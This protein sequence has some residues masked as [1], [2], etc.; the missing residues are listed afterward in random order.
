LKPIAESHVVADAGAVPLTRPNSMNL[1]STRIVWV[2][3]VVVVPLIVKFPPTVKFPLTEVVEVPAEP[4]MLMLVVEP[5][6]PLVPMLI[7]L[8]V[9]LAVAPVAKL[10]V[11]APVDAVNMFTDCAA[12]AVFPTVS[13]VAAP[14]KFTVVAVV[15]SKSNDAPP[16][17][18]DVVI[19]GLVPNTSAPVPV[20]LVTADAKFADEGVARNVATLAANPETPV[21]IGRPA[22][23]LKVPDC[24]VPK[25]GVVRV[26]EVLSTL[27]PEPVLVVTPVP[28]FATANVP[29]RVTAPLVAVLGVRPVV[30]AENDDTPVPATELLNELYHCVVEE[31]LNSSNELTGIEIAVF[32]AK[33]SI[34]VPV[35]G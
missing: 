31:A 7:V 22:Q 14:T 11:D 3:N 9:A 23:L 35:A 5:A 32:T 26:G 24:G 34:A 16:A 15:L 33:A 8:V 1:S 13:V 10:Y 12:V 20:S 27:L 17:T 4:P 2:F 19:V 30:P 21:E 18:N 28:P 29:A 25:I 6:T